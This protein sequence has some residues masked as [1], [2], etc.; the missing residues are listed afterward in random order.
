MSEAEGISRAGSPSWVVMFDDPKDRVLPN[1]LSLHVLRHLQGI[2]L[3][4]ACAAS[5]VWARLV[6]AEHLWQRACLHRWPVY[7][8]D[9]LGR[10]PKEASEEAPITMPPWVD[11]PQTQLLPNYIPARQDPRL[12]RPPQADAGPIAWRTFYL[13]HDLHE[14]LN[15]GAVFLS[16]TPLRQLHE[17][18]FTALEQ[19]RGWMPSPIMAAAAECQAAMEVVDQ[20]RGVRH[21]TLN[22]TALTQGALD[23][24]FATHELVLRALTRAAEPQ[25]L[26]SLVVRASHIA[27]DSDVYTV[28][29]SF[30]TSLLAHLRPTAAQLTDL[31]L[32]HS[33]L[34]A[35]GVRPV[36]KA[37][38]TWGE[39]PNLASL[40]LAACQLGDEG[41][42]AVATALSGYGSLC[43]LDLAQNGIGPAGATALCAAL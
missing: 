21:L 42:V 41:V 6:R 12:S 33:S 18:Y 29:S 1:D 9:S 8:V 26:R 19:V 34:H 5:A 37:L 4:A 25:G 36:C 11:A 17:T 24:P 31:D 23:R 2:E 7:F 27:V 14:C 22:I 38:C 13:E 3:V 35:D 16:V 28:P 30:V 32:S 20:L 39:L 15:I 10:L 43:S 40:G